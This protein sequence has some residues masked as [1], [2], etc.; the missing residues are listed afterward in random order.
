MPGLNLFAAPV[1]AVKLKISSACAV[2]AFSHAFTPRH[3]ISF[4]WLG[5]L[6]RRTWIQTGGEGRFSTDA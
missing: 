3:L 6:P 1:S 4:R 5:S 2:T